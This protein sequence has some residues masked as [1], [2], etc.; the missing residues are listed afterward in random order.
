MVDLLRLD[1]VLSEPI[2]N[3]KIKAFTLKDSRNISIQSGLTG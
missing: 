3:I 1:F 2:K